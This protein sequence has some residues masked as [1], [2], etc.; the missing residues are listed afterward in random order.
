L[1][2]VETDRTA[3][4]L[5]SCV[6]TDLAAEKLEV[7]NKSGAADCWPRKELQIRP[8]Q[9][10]NRTSWRK[11]CRENQQRNGRDCAARRPTPRQEKPTWKEEAALN[12]DKSSHELKEK[13]Q[14]KSTWTIAP[15]LRSG[16]DPENQNIPKIKLGAQEKGNSDLEP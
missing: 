12:E 15:D 1:T 9:P 4:V 3:P 6:R 8:F 14:E 10:G 7:E 2:R 5:E 13:T 16:I 11:L